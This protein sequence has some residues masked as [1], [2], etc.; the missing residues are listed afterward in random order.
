LKDKAVA[1]QGIAVLGIHNT[2]VVDI[3][4]RE[5]G[6]WGAII[7]DEAVRR[8]HQQ[9]VGHLVGGAAECDRV[10]KQAVDRAMV[11]RRERE[12]VICGDGWPGVV[13]DRDAERLRLGVIA[14]RA[15]ELERKTVEVRVIAAFDI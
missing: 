2:A 3:G 12:I 6:G 4:L 14:E 13:E 8:R 11:L 9:R 5:A 15:E 7:E 1:A 10:E